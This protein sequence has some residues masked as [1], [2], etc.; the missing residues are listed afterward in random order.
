MKKINSFRGDT[1]ILFAMLLFGGYSLFLRFFPEIPTI[2]FLFTFQVV[3]AT[4]FLVIALK[5]KQHKAARLHWKLLV[6]LAVCATLNDLAYFLAFRLTTVANAAV[7][8]QMVSVFLLFL[9]PIILKERTRNKEY[10]SLALSLVGIVVLYWDRSYFFG[11]S[12]DLVGITLGL[13]SALFYALIIILYRHI[14][15]RGLSISTIN[16]WRLMLSTLFL[17]PLMPTLGGF[18]ISASSLI[19]L[20]AFGILFAFIASGIH[21]LGISMTR[22]LH[23]SIL[24]KTEPV[25]AVIYAML[26]LG[27]IPALNAVL[28]GILIVGSGLWLAFEK[29]EK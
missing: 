3:G 26:F 19:P 23:S 2:T 16:F 24:G 6:A 12:S 13:I 1:L 25:I 8:H 29:S 11:G 22:P 27:E 14:P 7:A 9:A 21:N 20:V 10:W 15:T 17:L 4:T 28:G 5:H 18:N